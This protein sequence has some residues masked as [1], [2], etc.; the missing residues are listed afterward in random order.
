MD[1]WLSARDFARAQE[2]LQLLLD[3][4]FTIGGGEWAQRVRDYPGDRLQLENILRGR[5]DRSPRYDFEREVLP[6][7]FPS[8]GYSLKDRLEKADKLLQRASKRKLDMH[9]LFR[10]L[11]PDI[12]FFTGPV[13]ERTASEFMGK[14]LSILGVR[15]LVEA[16]LP[17]PK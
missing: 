8:R 4:V 2:Q 7:L 11:S 9:E 13:T 12:D 14:S 15:R 6:T 17:E 10:C 5:D 3:G 1:L 16:K